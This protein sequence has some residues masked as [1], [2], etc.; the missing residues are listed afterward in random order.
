LEKYDYYLE[1]QT[2]AKICI[3]DLFSRLCSTTV[4]QQ[5]TNLIDFSIVMIAQSKE[6]KETS[7]KSRNKTEKNGNLELI[8]D[9][10]KRVIVPDDIVLKTLVDI[11][12]SP[13]HPGFTKMYETIK[14]FI[15][16]KNLKKRIINVTEDCMLCNKNKKNSAKYGRIKGGLGWMSRYHSSSYSL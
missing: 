15:Y 3:A 13:L 2:K 11:H 7:R 14:N 5:E 12:R 1:N 8:C 4:K 16:I 9:S 6:R 10:K